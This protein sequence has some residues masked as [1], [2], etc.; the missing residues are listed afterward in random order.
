MA[1]QAVETIL[2]RQL[3]GYL[4]VPVLIADPLGAVVYYNE[5]AERLLGFRYDEAGRLSREEF[6]A[7]IEAGPLEGEEDVQPLQIALRNRRP[8]HARRRVTRRADGA[9]I[10]VEITAFPIVGQGDSFHGAVVMFWQ[11]AP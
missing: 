5:P 4:T 9:R 7:R 6:E 11:D 2:I 1:Q 8:A 3:A 10:V